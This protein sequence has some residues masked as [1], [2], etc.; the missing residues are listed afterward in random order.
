MWRAVGPGT[1]ETVPFVPFVPFE[2]EA[3]IGGGVEERDL[4][5]GAGEG[6]GEADRELL[7]ER[8]GSYVT[9]R[10]DGDGMYR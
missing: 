10:F 9:G 3:G 2:F 1:P 6:E 5:D 7:A 4:I 8:G